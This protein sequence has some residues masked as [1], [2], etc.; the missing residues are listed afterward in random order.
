MSPGRLLVLLLAALSSESTANPPED[1]GQKFIL[2]FPEN[3][4]YY[5]PT[6]SQNKVLITALYPDTK[7]TIKQHS[8]DTSDSTLEAGK[9]WEFDLDARMEL[10]KFNPT[11]KLLLITSTKNITVV[12]ISLRNDS[13]QTALVTPFEKLGKE[14]LI[15]PTPTIPG[16]T[17]QVS[18]AVTERNPFHLLIVSGDQGA[19]V[20]VEG[21]ETQEVSL[22]P[23]TTAKMWVQEG[24]Q[25]RTVTAD[26]PVAVLFGHPCALRHGCTCGLLYSP[27]P[28]ARAAK[29]RFFI[30]PALAEDAAEETFL[31]LSEKGSTKIKAFNPDSPEVEV[32]GT[33]ALYRPGLLLPL[34]PEA[35][36]ASCF[37]VSPVSG[38]PG[39]PGVPG[40]KSFAVIVVHRDFT[41]GVR[42]GNLALDS[43]EW[44]KLKGTEFM[45]T[46]VELAQ[47][48]TVIWHT[49]SRMAV[50]LAGTM[51][52]ALFGNPAAIISSSP[53]FRGCALT[54]EVVE[55][56]AVVSGW[57][58]S[59][60]YC[61]DKNL[62]LIS[63]SN[64]L[65][66][67]HIYK[68]IIQ[69]K[70]EDVQEVWIGMR[71]SSQTG[72]WYW[73]NNDAVNNTKWEEGEPGTVHDGQCAIM[74]LKS[75]EDFGWRD[76][77][78]CKAAHP[79]CYS[80]PVL[81]SL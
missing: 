6:A 75:D 3:I 64:A 22:E 36:F 59:L 24:A 77:D 51:G 5:H 26:Q 71:R 9:S 15:P 66:W 38:V 12:A 45:S 35:D 4:A 44:Q 8:F 81:L 74:S 34:I 40:P 19:T 33:A 21:A 18:L 61:R 7:V 14:Y 23:S 1:T 20:T 76:E 41:D 29:L 49:S 32:T 54:P 46:S 27:L 68:K 2:V 55:I 11:K 80:S 43:P 10:K 39:V 13:L 52:E 69:A 25:L 57:R 28:A 31:L 60:K 78:C 72:E 73:L 30:P 63:M 47:T 17:D 65:V 58:E 70:D 42:K 62:E 53:D 67:P 56:G 48:D 50:Y 16:T 79:V 37:A